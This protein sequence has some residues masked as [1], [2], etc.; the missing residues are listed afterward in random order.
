MKD[1][2]VNLESCREVS[3]TIEEA[4]RR[5]LKMAGPFLFLC[6]VPFIIIHGWQPFGEISLTGL[7][8]FGLTS[9]LGIAIHELIH[10]FVFGLFGKGGFKS[11]RF[12]IDRKTWSPYCHPAT[13][14]KV[15]VYR[16]GALAPLVIL[17]I[18]PVVVS[19]YYASVFW[20]FFGVIFTI[21]AG[22]DIISVWLTRNLSS[23]DI[24]RDH[25][26]KLGFYIIDQQKN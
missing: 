17:G 11:I 2:D 9:I 20:L 24:V 6:L 15:W 14:M 7:M 8:W 26:S 3:I 13:N 1:N 16:T 12:G 19:L 25:T 4:G 5:A 23:G 22:G 21:A 18:A 10:A